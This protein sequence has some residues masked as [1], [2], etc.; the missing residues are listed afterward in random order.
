M[1]PYVL[2]A[3]TFVYV[4][5]SQLRAALKRLNLSQMELARR[6][7][8]A[9]TTVRRWV[10]RKRPTRIPESVALLVASWERS[11]H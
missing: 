10:M 4:T 6:L 11:K 1:L 8:V 9:P 7:H 2:G 3:Y 5:A